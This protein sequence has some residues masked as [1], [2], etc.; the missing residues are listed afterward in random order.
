LSSAPKEVKQQQGSKTLG[1]EH[2][3]VF[4]GQQ[5]WLER[6]RVGKK[7]E[8]EVREEQGLYHV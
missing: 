8:N 2:D 1:Q 7:G 4:R 3:Q 5:E 6:V